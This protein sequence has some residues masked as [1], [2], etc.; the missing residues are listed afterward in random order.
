MLCKGK[1]S[2]A[3]S[4]LCWCP[5]CLPTSKELVD[6]DVPGSPAIE[7]LSYVPRTLP[8]GRGPHL[9]SWIDCYRNQRSCCESFAPS[10]REMVCGHREPGS[11][12]HSDRWR[13]GTPL[14]HPIIIR[15]LGI[16]SGQMANQSGVLQE[17]LDSRASLNFV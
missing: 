17:S 1:Q 7:Q 10:M 5:P 14:N 11:F 8:F 12:R 6:D 16:Y 9:D 15:S 4:I 3:T 13:L 2:D